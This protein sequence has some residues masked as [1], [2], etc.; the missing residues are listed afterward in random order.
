MHEVVGITFKD[1]GPMFYFLAGDKKLKKNL[2]V[3]VE[4]ERGLGFGKI[5]TDVFNLNDDQIKAPLKNIVRIASKSDYYQN[6][7]NLQDAAKALK[8]AKELAKK[9]NLEMSIISAS[10]TFE[11]NQLIFKFVADNRVD[12]RNLAKELANIYKT[13]IELRQ[14]GVR[15]KAREVGGLGQCGCSL[16]CSKFLRDFDSVSINMAKNQNIALNPSKINGICG[17]LMCCLKYEDE[18]YKSCR[19]G[20]PKMGSK[21]KTEKGEGTII[22]IDILK[23]SYT[24]EVPHY[25]TI[26][27]QVEADE[28]SK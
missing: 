8:K 14:V 12:F 9:N 3:I 17:R 2:T 1:K 22:A 28:N 13:R 4:T 26:E 15:D 5:V 23:R 7:R 11:R 21:V 10:Y 18:C 27:M 25:G 20:L 16:C 19:K 6:K 24:V